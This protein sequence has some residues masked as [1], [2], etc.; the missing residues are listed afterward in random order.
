MY[1]SSPVQIAELII[2]FKI[3]S[4]GKEE[5]SLLSFTVV[6]TSLDI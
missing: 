6:L 5:K 2:K 1:S 3:D 4:F